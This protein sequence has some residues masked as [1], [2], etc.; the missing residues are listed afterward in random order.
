MSMTSHLQKAAPKP[1]QVP[2]AKPLQAAAAS[3]FLKRKCA[4]GAG[5]SGIAGE[6]EECSSKKMMGLQTK[7]RVNEP[8]DRCE[9]EADRVAE[10]VLGKPAHPGV[11]SAPSRIQ[12]IPE[13]SNEQMDIAPPSVDRALES[14]GRRLEPALRQDMERRFGH[15]FSRVRVHSDAAAQQSA[16][17]VNAHAFTVG[18]DIVFGTGR[19]APETHAGRQLIAHELTHVVQGSANIGTRVQQG[20]ENSGLKSIRRQPEKQSKD[21]PKE[22]LKSEG[23]DLK[24]PAAAST[25]TIIDDVLARNERLR[26]YI[27]DRLTGGFKIAA[28][29]KFILDIT[30]G[31]FDDA[32]RDAYV[33][34]SSVT[35]SKDTK[36]FYNP[37]N[38]RSIC[39]RVQNSV[40]LCTNRF[41]GWRRL[42]CT[43]R[44]CRRH[45]RFRTTSPR[46]SKRE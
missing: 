31:N 36:G 12:P 7:L 34:N 23:V 20:D 8:G 4:C 24:D 10:Q 1:Q 44:I 16:Q 25:A 29:G 32:Y 37:R 45:T 11:S 46:F 2:T 41:T 21:Q 9:Q 3:L 19:F 43:V 40:P 18:H 13:P 26:P 17:D 39:A 27:G 33:L 35:V 22:T 28:K 6:C 5:T 42:V 30:D 38:Q 14:P 15:D